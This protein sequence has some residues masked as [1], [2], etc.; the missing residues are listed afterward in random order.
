MAGYCTLVLY[1]HS[2]VARENTAAHSCNIQ[3]YCLLT[4]QIIYYMNTTEQPNKCIILN[5]TEQPNK[6]IILNT[7]EQPNKCI[8]LNT[9]KELK[10]GRPGY[11]ATTLLHAQQFCEVVVTYISSLASCVLQ[12][13]MNDRFWTFTVVWKILFVKITIQSVIKML[14]TTMKV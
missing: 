12:F 6:C 13:L 3:P 2:P 11:E 10:R 5:T 4:H 14:P 1:F 8:I 9:T 7:T